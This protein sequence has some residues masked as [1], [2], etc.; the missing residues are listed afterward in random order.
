[1]WARPWTGDAGAQQVERRAH[2]DH[3]RLE[4]RV[5]DGRAAELR[6]A[7]R[8]GPARRRRARGA[9]ACSRWSAG[10]S[11]GRRSARRRAR[12]RAPVT[13][14]SSATVPIAVPQRSKP[15]GDGWPRIS[16]GSTASSPPGI[17]MPASA[18]PTARPRAI[19]AVAVG[20]GLLDGEVVDHRDR[21]GADADE[22]VDVHRDAVDPDGVEP[23]G[24][25]G[26]RRAS[27]RRRRWRSRSRGP[28]SRAGRSRS[29]RAGR[30]RATARRSRSC[31]ARRRSRRRRG[32][33]G[34]C[35]RRRR[36]T[37]RS[38]RGPCIGAD[39]RRSGAA[40]VTAARAPRYAAYGHSAPT[41]STGTSRA[42]AS[43]ETSDAP[44]PSA[45]RPPNPGGTPRR[46]SRAPLSTLAPGDHRQRDVARQRARLAAR[47]AA[48]A[49]RGERHA[50]ARE[51][52]D[53]RAR[54]REAE[55]ERVDRRSRPRACA[56]WRPSASATT[57]ATAPAA[58]PAAIV[59]AVPS[60]CSIGRSNSRPA[61]AGGH[62]RAGEQAHAA[63]VEPV[64]RLGDLAAQ[65]DQQADRGA[66]VQRDLERLAQLAVELRVGPAEQPGDERRVPGRGDRQQ[67]GGPVQQPER[68]R[69]ARRQA[70]PRRR[71]QAAGA[72]AASPR[73]AAPA[74]AAGRSRRRRSPRATA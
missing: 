45:S 5:G 69:V 73:A 56:A 23:A 49:H 51:A 2:V 25:L 11:T 29:G 16:S 72:S 58:R 20:V 21:L 61:A 71:G 27:S 32:R 12:C 54:L 9:R 13:I 3:G 67:L 35:R 4:Q 36:R 22:V 64:R 19:A 55:R 18:A 43:V 31:A 48:R 62:E 53:Q 57:I 34:R 39:A 6:R 28:A 8:R 65:R 63:A 26:E 52:R 60:R 68:Q 44:A 74:H 15:C 7:W 24:L 46:A 14:A 59:R 10:R 40:Y 47:E 30:R 50:A 38:S 70:S 66:G 1:M 41:R 42:A 17:S 33:T 37:R